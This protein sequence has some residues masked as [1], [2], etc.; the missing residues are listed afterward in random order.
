MLTKLLLKVLQPNK[1][2]TISNYTL[3]QRSAATTKLLNILLLLRAM[4]VNILVNCE[5]KQREYFRNA[6][7]QNPSSR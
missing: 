4:D 6:I 1:M 7:E 5:L 2:M 3:L